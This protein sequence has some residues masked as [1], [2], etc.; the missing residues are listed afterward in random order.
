MKEMFE[1][2]GGVAAATLTASVIIGMLLAIL[3]PGSPFHDVVKEFLT[4]SM[5]F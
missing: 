1:E 5:P 4:A 3:I 2:Y